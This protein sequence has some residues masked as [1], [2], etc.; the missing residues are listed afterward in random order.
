MELQPLTIAQ[1]FDRSRSAFIGLLPVAHLSVIVW[2]V[3]LPWC[4]GLIALL[5]FLFGFG[6]L[7][8]CKCVTKGVESLFVFFV[9]V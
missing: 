6:R 7:P 9:I 3:G 5:H 4:V 2:S 1:I 8:K